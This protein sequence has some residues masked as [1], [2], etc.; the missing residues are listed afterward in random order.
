MRNL[1]I[2]FLSSFL[3]FGT[4]SFALSPGEKNLRNKNSYSDDKEFLFPG[5]GFFK[6]NRDPLSDEE[7]KRWFIDAENRKRWRYQRGSSFMRIS[8]NDDRILESIYK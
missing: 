7:A 2:I 4:F 6:K 3:I 8:P 1:N 5:T